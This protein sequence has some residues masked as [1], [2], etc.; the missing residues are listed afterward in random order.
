[1]Y[2]LEL[3][4]ESS[5]KPE[6]RDLAMAAE[7]EDSADETLNVHISTLRHKLEPFGLHILSKPGI[8][9]ILSTADYVCPAT[10][11]QRSADQ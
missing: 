6:S 9:Y 4:P 2:N 5:E 7:F 8:G 1:L 3:G 11:A 10:D